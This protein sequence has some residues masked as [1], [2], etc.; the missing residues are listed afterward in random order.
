[1][2]AIGYNAQLREPLL[3]TYIRTCSTFCNKSGAGC[4]ERSAPP[5]QNINI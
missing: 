3:I 2:S 4:G 5:P 1:M